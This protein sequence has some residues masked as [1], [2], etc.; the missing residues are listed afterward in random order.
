ME[1][2][3]PICLPRP[4][5]RPELKYQ[6]RGASRP[7]EEVAKFISIAWPSVIAIVVG[8]LI[9]GTVPGAFQGMASPKRT[10][11]PVARVDTDLPPIAVD[12]RDVAEQAG[13]TGVVVSG[14]ESR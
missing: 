3:P 5:S 10:P 2:V 7:R 9:S 12:F 6:K 8:V 14:D 13:L 4:G 11:K 1:P